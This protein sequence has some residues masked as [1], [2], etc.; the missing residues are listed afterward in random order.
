MKSLINTLTVI[1]ACVVL[2]TVSAVA[3]VPKS[4]DVLVVGGTERGIRAAT[5]AAKDG[6]SVYLVTP[7]PYLGEDLAGTLELGFG[8]DCPTDP[9][10]VRLW[11]DERGLA[12]FDYWPERETDGIRW[13]YRNDKWA[14]FS[15]P[16]MPPTMDDGVLYIDDVGIRCVM[17]QPQKITAVRVLVLES[18][19]PVGGNLMR[20]ADYARIARTKPG[21]Q[22]VGTGAVEMKYLS[23]P[24]TG[25]IVALRRKGE[26]V[27]VPRGLAYSS[28]RGVFF[29]ASVDAELSEVLVTARVDADAHHQLVSRIWFQLADS[30]RSFTPPSP[31]KVKRTFDRELIGAGVGFLTSSPVRRVMR[32]AAGVPTGVEIVNRSGRH[33]IRAGKVMDATRYGLLGKTPSVAKEELFSRVVIA[34]RDCPHAPGMRVEEIPSAFEDP[35]SNMKGRMYRCSFKLPM[36]DGA[37]PSFAAAEWAARELTKLE[38]PLDDADMLVW[39]PS[40]GACANAKATSDE[41]PEWGTYDV[42]VIGG[43]TSGAPAGIAA[44]RCG[45]KTL[46]VEYRDMLGGVGTDGMVLGYFDGNHCGF[47]KEFKAACAGSSVANQYRRAEVWR[48]MCNAAG[49]TVWLGALG[50]GVVRDGCKVTGVEI[51]TPFGTGI[52]RAKCVIDGTGNSDV[53]AAAGAATE[54]VSAAEIAVQSA[55]QSPQ[56]L[57]KGGINSDFGYLNDADAEDL[58]LFGVRARAGAPNAWDIAKLPDSR[59]RRRIVPDERL[60][61]EDVVARRTYPDTVAQALSRQDPHGYLTDDFGYLAEVSTEQVPGVFEKRLMYR[62]N[63]PLR[64]LLPKGVDGLAVVGL[65]AGIERD[66]L[67]ITRMQAD[68]MNM[69]YG[70]GLAAALAA[71]NGGDFRRIDLSV[72]RQR[73]VEKGILDRAAL[74]WTKDEDITSDAVLEAAVKTL[75]DGY[76]GGHVL[77]RRENRSRALPLLRAAYRSA[78]EAGAR[79]TYALALGLMGDATG[80]ETLLA[81]ARGDENIVNV[82]S[83]SSGPNGKFARSYSA[84]SVRD[85]VL[86]ALA[87]TGDRRG[88]EPLLR[89]LHGTTVRTPFGDVRKLMLAIEASR[90]PAFARPLSKLLASEGIGGHAVS[91]MRTLPPLGGYG[92]G[93]EFES[94]FRELAIARALLACGD[95]DGLARRTYEAY[96]KDPRGIL[97]VHA[98]AVLAAAGR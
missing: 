13:I 38:R 85:G 14:R 16:G 7:H 94:C 4:V 33:V 98:K 40:P 68:L 31:L 79:Q 11:R 45:A 71:K 87:R 61:G 55:G 3:A 65:G 88:S 77:Y 29:E 57:G 56:R 54:F 62:V 1:G 96:A 90:D 89:A 19:S 76:R 37:Y 78:T 48:T 32:D 63:L 5:E 35:H 84:G 44:A 67:A 12:T 26:T 95:C 20:E 47:T 91:D 50:L 42:V 25:E 18:D 9:L 34:D 72:L 73:L 93:L 30:C 8:K 70:V 59:E 24:K 60:T 69:G 86:L 52:V 21:A 97:A 43:G 10:G 27:E 74:D 53:A 75:P 2:T 80:I 51:S 66:V 46:I 6:K 15:E 92:I 49:V 82:R 22:R 17:R 41:L 58:W 83:V 28:G 39:H 36:K 64:C 23:G 81:C